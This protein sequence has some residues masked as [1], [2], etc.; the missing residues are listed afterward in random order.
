[1]TPNPLLTTRTL[2]Q[3]QTPE[4]LTNL[5]LS[6]TAPAYVLQSSMSPSA[7]HASLWPGEALLFLI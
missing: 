3:N 2:T 4:L 5:I 1:M 6:V 7:F